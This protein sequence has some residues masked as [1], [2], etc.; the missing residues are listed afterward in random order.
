MRR[1]IPKSLPM[2]QNNGFGQATFITQRHLAEE[3]VK[4]PK[5]DM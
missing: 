4:K 2:P 1:T 3:D 5:K